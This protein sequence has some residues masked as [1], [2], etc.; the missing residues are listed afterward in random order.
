ML[1]HLENLDGRLESIDSRLMPIAQVAQYLIDSG[2]LEQ[3]VRQQTTNPTN[4]LEEYLDK[5]QVKDYLGIGETTYYRWVKMGKLNPRG[6]KGQ[7]RYYRRDVRELMER[8]RYRKR[9]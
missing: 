5:E 8:R 3:L 9:G 1:K 2:L 4:E 6:G 7:H